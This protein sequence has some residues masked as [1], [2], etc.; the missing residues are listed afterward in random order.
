[1]A[2]SFH[3]WE[4][5]RWHAIHF[6][7]TKDS[8]CKTQ[9]MNELSADHF[10]DLCEQKWCMELHHWSRVWKEFL[11]VIANLL[12]WALSLNKPRIGHECRLKYP[13]WSWFWRLCKNSSG[14][15]SGIWYIKYFCLILYYI[16]LRNRCLC[17]FTLQEV[18]VV[19][20][21]NDVKIYINNFFYHQHN[22][23]LSLQSYSEQSASNF[24][25]FSGKFS[26][27]PGITNNPGWNRQVNMTIAVI[28]TIP[29]QIKG[30]WEAFSESYETVL[31]GYA[32][33]AP[34]QQ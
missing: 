16:T 13:P 19:G 1:M 21:I 22:V 8:N 24:F 28:S 32:T 6:K 4:R 11:D 2:E 15:L 23:D 25:V 17:S 12:L 29:T 9:Q 20:Y 30:D 34:N 7:S 18:S 10:V 33:Q 27:N 26:D 14:I 31:V 5:L 3:I